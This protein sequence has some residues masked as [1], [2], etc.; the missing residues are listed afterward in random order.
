M[1]DKN[2]RYFEKASLAHCILKTIRI[3]NNLPSIFI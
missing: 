1:K 3:P 2:N